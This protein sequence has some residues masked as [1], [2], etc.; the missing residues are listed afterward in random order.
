MAVYDMRVAS[1]GDWMNIATGQ[2]FLRVETTSSILRM[3]DGL[4]LSTRQLIVLS[5]LRR[6]LCR[7]NIV[8]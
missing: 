4:L 7:I 2:Q 8:Q 6:D 5:N 1:S 3:R